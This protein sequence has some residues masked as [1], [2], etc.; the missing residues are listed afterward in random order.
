MR[1]GPPAGG[2]RQ[3]R[4]LPFL[5]H[6]QHHQR[7]LPDGSVPEGCTRL[8]EHRR[9]RQ[10]RSSNTLP[11]LVL[12]VFVIYYSFSSCA[13]SW[14]YG[15]HACV[16]RVLAQLEAQVLLGEIIRRVER[17]ELDGE[18]TPWMTTV[19]HGPAKLPIRV[20]AA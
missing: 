18:P 9:E 2:M 17:I 16:G 1:P 13:V 20:D 12:L 11:C 6:P 8:P 10:T 5:R 15:I 7:H 14:G 19:G 4:P 3:N